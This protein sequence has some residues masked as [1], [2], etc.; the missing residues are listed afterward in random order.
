[1]KAKLLLAALALAAGGCAPTRVYQPK[2]A[3]EP[4]QGAAVLILPVDAQLYLRNDEGGYEPEVAESAAA[5]A[6]LSGALEA[7]L[8]R[9]GLKPI[10][11]GDGKQA[12]AKAG[13][14]AGADADAMRDIARQA[15][16][17]L[18]AIETAQINPAAATSRR[19]Y[20]L[21]SKRLDDLKEY[22]AD[23]ALFVMLR[24][25]R[26]AAGAPIGIPLMEGEFALPRGAAAYRAALFDLR[27]GQLTWAN[28]TPHALAQLP[29]AQAIPA[30]W[31]WSFP[32]LFAKFPL[33]KNPAPPAPLPPPE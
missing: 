26:T 22:Q 24:Y 2:E 28:F 10:K 20:A 1:M 25:T 8:A 4:P 19:E 3:L 17:N 7:F 31:H 16:I 14:S 6:E 18:D 33:F 30:H 13:A 29:P 27:G 9:M 23:Y 11:H 32:P 12:E 15:N 5:A 21:T